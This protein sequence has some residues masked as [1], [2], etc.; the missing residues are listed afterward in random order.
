MEISWDDSHGEPSH[1]QDC[2]FPVVRSLVSSYDWLACTQYL[3]QHWEN[4]RLARPGLLV[5]RSP[6]FSSSRN[7]ILLWLSQNTWMRTTATAVKQSTMEIVAWFEVINNAPPLILFSTCALHF[8]A[9]KLLFFFV[10]IWL[11]RKGKDNA[12]QEANYK[13]SKWVVKMAKSINKV[14]V[15]Q[16]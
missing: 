12:E 10:L 9:C 6:M 8:I 14:P 13:D 11:S 2:Q 16:K 3:Q 1:T 15:C 5:I 4:V 7:S